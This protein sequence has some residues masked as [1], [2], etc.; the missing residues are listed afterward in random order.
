[1]LRSLTASALAL[2]ATTALALPAG[3]SAEIVPVDDVPAATLLLPYFEIDLGANPAQ[4][5]TLPAQDQPAQA[6]QADEG[7]DQDKGKD[8]D[9]GKGKGKKK[10]DDKGKNR[11]K[12]K[13]DDKD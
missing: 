4:P 3:A 8:N 2:L 11:G 1:M 10:D 9:K 7:K 12:G 13:N 6:D 5:T